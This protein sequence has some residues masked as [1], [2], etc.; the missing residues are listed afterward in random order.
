MEGTSSQPRL[1][2]KLRG[3]R[4]W[5]GRNGHVPG[6]FIGG[7][8]VGAVP[9]PVELEVGTAGMWRVPGFPLLT[10]PMSKVAKAHLRISIIS[11]GVLVPFIPMVFRSSGG[12][13]VRKQSMTS[14]SMTSVAACHSGW[15]HRL[16]TWSSE[17]IWAREVDEGR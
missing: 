5:L 3:C 17:S 15:S 1:L 10:P 12:R 9:L 14:R 2:E 4:V 6:C 8:A 7:A 13:A 11:P 16:V